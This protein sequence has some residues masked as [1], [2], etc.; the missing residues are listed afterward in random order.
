MAQR[1]CSRCGR[2]DVPLQVHHWAPRARFE[3]A[4][5][6]PTSALCHDCH[7]SWHRVM[8]W[9]PEPSGMSARERSLSERLE[10]QIQEYAMAV[11]RE[12]ES[13]AY[14]AVLAELRGTEAADEVRVVFGTEGEL[15]RAID[16]AAEDAKIA[17]GFVWVAI[18]RLVFEP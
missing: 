9:R 8:G 3:D 6:W 7:V 11:A 17:L 12:R 16:R 4:D 5:D 1:F 10:K 14:R 18:D 13:V 2:R 15:S